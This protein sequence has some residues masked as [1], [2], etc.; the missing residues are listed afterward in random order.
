MKND[1][2]KRAINTKALIAILFT[3]S[4]IIFSEQA[5]DAAV[6]GLHTWWEVVF[7][8]LLPFFIMA[9]I[10]MGL[11]V[12]HFMG[13]LL[14]PLMQP[15]FKVPGVGAFAF[16]MGLASGYPIGAK[17]TGN[18]RRKKLCTQAE[19]ERLVSFTNTADPLFM[20]GAVAV[21]MFGNAKLG[22]I[23]AL[24]HYISCLIVG[25]GLRFYNPKENNQ[26]VS[27]N[28]DTEGNI[29]TRAFSELY[30]ARRKDGRSLGQL[31]G[32]A[33]KESLNTLLLIG[34]Y[35]ILFSVL[36]RV[37]ALVG[38][39]K[40]IT[41]GIVFVLKPFGFDQS[42]VLPIISG[43]F[44]ITNGSHLAS[45]SMA[46]LNQKIIITSGIIAWS[47]LSVH[48][49]VAT[50]INGTDLRMKP[51]LW[52][53]VFHG[54]IA[55]LVTYFLFEPLEAISSNLITPVT[56]LANRVNYTIGYWDHF[57]KMSSGLLLFLGFLIFTSL[58]IYFIKKI[59]LVM[60]HYSE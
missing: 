51:Y 24:A 31:I 5:F 33:T 29:F 27:R 26:D 30:Q 10:L 39:T 7:P 54:I 58:T 16:A 8:A 55:S 28:N 25:I 21:G 4:L 1:I 13:T 18:L 34:G 56:S 42:L 36:T 9:E 53:R 15:V 41:A 17:I 12:V 50:M 44:E 49:Q 40:L 14:E 37:L 2:N 59:K 3:I 32:D 48:A 45:Q 57:T 11:G 43:L 60:F 52:A 6:S 22:T 23:L 20:I 19:G 35:I 46:P 47:G 38:F